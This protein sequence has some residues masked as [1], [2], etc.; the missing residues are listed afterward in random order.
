MASHTVQVTLDPIFN[1]LL[2]RQDDLQAFLLARRVTELE[3]HDLAAFIRNMSLALNAEV[4]EVLEETYWK[5]WAKLPSDG[6]IV[7]SKTRYTGELADVFIFFMNLML[8]GGVTMADLA[9]AVDAK[10]TK[11][12]MRWTNGYDAKSTKCMGCKRSFD[13]PDVNC[14]PHVTSD[15]PGAVNVL[16]FCADKERF[17][18]REGNS[19]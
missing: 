1:R 18:D 10:Q 4:T 16:A 2:N 6:V 19:V 15:E 3:P 17:I 14:Y 13:D 8:A 5:P 11:N 9:K 7:P 12:L